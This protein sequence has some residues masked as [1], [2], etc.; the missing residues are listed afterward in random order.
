MVYVSYSIY[1]QVY[2][3][4]MLTYTHTH[5]HTTPSFIVLVKAICSHIRNLGLQNGN[6]QRDQVQIVCF[7]ALLPILVKCGKYTTDKDVER[8]HL[9]ASH[10]SLKHLFK[11]EH[12]LSINDYPII[13]YTVYTQLVYVSV[14][15]HG[16]HNNHAEPEGMH[17]YQMQHQE[18]QEEQ[19]LH[20]IVARW[21]L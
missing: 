15:C 20:I 4:C 21:L 16:V 1:T 5:T 9:I 10:H 18:F 17:L 7:S 14:H 2:I 11:I 12:K 19:Y 13:L 8:T 3:L 6:R